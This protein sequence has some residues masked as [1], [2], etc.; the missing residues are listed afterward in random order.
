MDT[1]FYMVRLT[2]AQAETLVGFKGDEWKDVAADL[3]KQLYPEQRRD[4]FKTSA[5]R[6]IELLKEMIYE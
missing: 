5:K 6:V 1:K 2:R 3:E 4:E